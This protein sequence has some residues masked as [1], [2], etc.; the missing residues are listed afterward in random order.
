MDHQERAGAA[1][2]AVIG[3]RE[4]G[5]DREII[6]GVRIHQAG[7]DGV[8]TLRRLAVA[9]LDL[10]SE[11]ARP[12]ADRIGLEQRETAGLVLFPD[13][14]FGFFLEDPHQDRRFLRHVLVF[15]VGDHAVGQR[16]HV[17]A[18]DGGRAIG[19]AT[20]KRNGRRNRSGRQERAHQRSTIQPKTPRS[21]RLPQAF[22]AQS[23]HRNEPPPQGGRCRLNMPMVNER[24]QFRS[25]RSPQSPNRMGTLGQDLGKIRAKGKKPGTGDSFGKQ[26]LTG[27]FSGEMAPAASRI[28]RTSVRWP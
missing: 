5:I 18:A 25:Q 22:P 1:V 2:R 3:V 28:S 12:A 17:A 16:L 9:L 15:D 14:E 4:A 11:L 21:L 24:A 10:G 26:T 6:V 19:V 20:G 7:S 23:L 8:E 13:F 27:H